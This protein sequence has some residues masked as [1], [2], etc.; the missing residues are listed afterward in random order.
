MSNSGKEMFSDELTRLKNPFIS[1]MS[2]CPQH[3][4]A[5]T[6]LCTGIFALPFCQPGG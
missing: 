4:T 3:F 2:A 1:R 6:A 5:L